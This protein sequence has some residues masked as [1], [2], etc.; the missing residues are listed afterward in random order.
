MKRPPKPPSVVPAMKKLVISVAVLSCQVSPMY[1][2]VTANS[3]GMTTPVAIRPARNSANESACAVQSI[4]AASSSAASVMIRRRSRRRVSM[5]TNGAVAAIATVVAV[6]PSAACS[7]RV[8]NVAAIWG[9][10]PC[11]AYRPRK[12]AQPHMKNAKRSVLVTT[13]RFGLLKNDSLAPARA[14]PPIPNSDRLI[15]DAQWRAKRGPAAFAHAG[16]RF[17]C[18]AYFMRVARRLHPMRF[19]HVSSERTIPCFLPR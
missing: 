4:G 10:M 11:V 18:L 14:F 13:V 6:M 19:R 1:D 17:A 9:R 12:A 16:A 2:T 15:P 3:T 7:M 8:P 5:P